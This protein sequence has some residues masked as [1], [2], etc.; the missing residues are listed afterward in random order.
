VLE[1]DAGI[2]HPDL[3]GV[4]PRLRDAQCSLDG[5]DAVSYARLAV[6]V[7]VVLQRVYN[8]RRLLVERHRQTQAAAG[9]EVQRRT[10]DCID[11]GLAGVEQI[12]PVLETRGGRARREARRL[13][14][15]QGY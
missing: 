9:H 1:Y 10:E 14:A 15:E 12:H 3:E 8:S 7:R 5:T 4:I 13:D 2:D 11:L 6:P